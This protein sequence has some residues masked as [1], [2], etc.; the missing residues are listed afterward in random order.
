MGDFQIFRFDYL[1]LKVVGQSIY[2]ISVF[3]KPTNKLFLIEKWLLC[4]SFLLSHPLSLPPSIPPSFPSFLFLD[5]G[6][7][8]ATLLP[9]FWLCFMACG[10]SVPQPGIEPGHNSESPES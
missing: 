6:R 1:D 3:K 4:P 9:F 10:I 2:I 7:M 5:L 8:S